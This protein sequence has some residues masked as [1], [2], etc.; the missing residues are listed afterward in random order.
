MSSYGDT[1]SCLGEEGTEKDHR[2]L[3]SEKGTQEEKSIF[4]EQKIKDFVSQMLALMG[5]CKIGVE[6]SRKQLEIKVYFIYHLIKR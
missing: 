3:F 6:E 4:R 5:L 1:E 2:M